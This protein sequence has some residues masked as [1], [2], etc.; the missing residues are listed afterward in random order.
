MTTSSGLGPRNGSLLVSVLYICDKGKAVGWKDSASNG[1]G[2]LVGLNITRANIDGAAVGM[3]DATGSWTRSFGRLV[4]G[5]VTLGASFL[6]TETVGEL[7]RLLLTYFRTWVVGASSTGISVPGLALLGSSTRFLSSFGVL[8]VNFSRR[9]TE[10]LDFWD[11]ALLDFSFSFF[12]RAAA[13]A[14]SFDILEPAWFEEPP[15]SPL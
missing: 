2:S 7:L 3:E 5:A 11:S 10:E 6:G 15:R 4:E 8:I 14:A 12:F 9:A 1:L 13:S